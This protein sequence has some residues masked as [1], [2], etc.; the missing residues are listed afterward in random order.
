LFV[1]SAQCN[2]IDNY[3]HVTRNNYLLVA[4]IYR[5]CF[6]HRGITAAERRVG[7]GYCARGYVLWGV[8]TGGMCAKYLGAPASVRSS[9]SYLNRQ[10]PAVFRI[11]RKQARTHACTQACNKISNA[12]RIHGRRT[13]VPPCPKE[14]EKKEE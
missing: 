4:Y 5:V 6:W 14:K 13:A 12:D 9:R 10:L 2:I 7:V 11:V 3:R 1:Y 8:T